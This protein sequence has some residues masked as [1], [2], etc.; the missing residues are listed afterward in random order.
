MSRPHGPDDAGELLLRDAGL[1]QALAPPLLVPP[2]PE[3][4]DV[5]RL[6]VERGD[7]RRLVE[8]VVVRQDDDSRLVVGATSASASSGHLGTSW[9][10]EGMRSA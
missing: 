7:Q 3:R 10:A 2:R 5:E 6:G 9:S 1:E 4:A 8:L